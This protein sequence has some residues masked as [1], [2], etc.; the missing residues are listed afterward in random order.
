MVR[1]GACASASPCPPAKSVLTVF[2]AH[3]LTHDTVEHLHIGAGHPHPAPQVAQVDLHAFG[4]FRGKEEP[5]LAQPVFVMFGQLFNLD[6]AG[7][8][9][10]DQFNTL[11][12]GTADSIRAMTHKLFETCGAGGGYLCS[13]ADHFFETDPANIQAFAD[14]A[15]ECES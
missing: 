13:M 4:L 11:T 14:A 15:R 1:V 7:P 8:I 3:H 12:R 9:G 5:G 2:P 6:R 10:F